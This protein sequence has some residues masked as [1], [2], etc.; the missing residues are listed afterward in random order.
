[1]KSQQTVQKIVKVL[2]VLSTIAFVC[3]IIS[4]V[5]LLLCGG[6]L[7]SVTEELA[8]EFVNYA[9]EL[10]EEYAFILEQYAALGEEY[11]YLFFQ[12]LGLLL[13]AEAIIVI[14]ACVVEGFICSYLK[15]VL[16]DGTPFTYEGAKKL[17]RVGIIGLALPI[18]TAMLSAFILAPTFFSGTDT[19][20]SLTAGIAYI[21]LSYLLEYGAA[22]EE[23]ARAA[24]E[25]AKI[26]ESGF[27]QNYNSADNNEQE[28]E[29]INLFGNYNT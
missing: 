10:D 29:P 21:L 5:I 4:S 14:G 6:M 3:L 8:A 1:M 12:D 13:I 28:K 22:I 25:R 26:F 11:S 20:V 18:G 23:R 24:E 19:T 16:A 9:I 7:L 2:K 15:G 17:R 27:E